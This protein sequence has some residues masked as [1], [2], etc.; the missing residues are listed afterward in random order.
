MPI[1]FTLA[2]GGRGYFKYRPSI[3]WMNAHGR[4]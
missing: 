1:E 2:L 3:A 4:S